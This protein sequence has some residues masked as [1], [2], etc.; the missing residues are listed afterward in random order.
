MKERL[1]G[2]DYR[3]VAVCLVLL[4]GTTWYSVR[5]FYRAFPEASIDFRVSR[6]EAQGLG[7]GFLSGLGYHIGGYREASSF[8]FDDDAKTFLEREAGLERANQLMET[9]VRLWRWSYRWFRPL[10]KEEF[11]AE[12]TTR[13][14]LA[15]FTHSLP[16]DAPLPAVSAAEASALAQD[17]LRARLHRDPASL[18]FVEASDVTRPHRTDRVFTWKERDFNLHDATIRLEVTVLGNQVGGYREYLKIP[19]Q[20]SRDYERLRSKNEM[21]QTVDTAVMLAL[22]VGMVVV[23][24]MRVRGQEIRW[25]RAA[26]V[27]TVGMAL[28][29]FSSLNE[30]P[31]HEFGYPTTDAYSAF[32]LR[33]L[34]QAVLA[35]LGAGGLLFVLTAGAE[36]LYREAFP[37]KVA[38][39]NLFRPR[40]LRTKRFFLGS[41]LGITLTGVFIAYQTFFYIVAYRFGAWSPADVP[42]SDLLN[43]RFPWLFVLFG[44][45]LP[46]VSEE[47]LFRMFA[48]PFLR[49]LVRS[50][51]VAVVLAGFIWGF[52]HAGYPQQPFYIRGVE[53]GIGG[54]ALGLIMLRWG[55]L[56]TLVW[57]YSVDAM[58]SA[59]LLL[60]SQSLYF[61]LSG[62]A[63][64]GIIVLP[65]MLALVA[66]WRR[67]GFEPE[68]GLLNADEVAPAEP[69]PEAQ[70]EPPAAAPQSRPLTARFRL[71]ALALFA[72]GLLSL[73]L[74]VNR[75]GDSPD[76]KL[77]SEQARNAA[78]AFL[79]AQGLDPA[80]Y[81]NVTF[82]SVHWGGDDSLAGKYLLERLPVSAASRL[83]ERY[84]PVQNWQSRY[85]KPLDQD[86]VLVSVQPETGRILGFRHTLPEDRPG[87]DVSEDTAR[88]VAS[89]FAAAQGWNVAD[90]DLKENNTEKKKARRDY[91][92][93][94]EARPGDPR[95]VAEAHYRVEVGVSGDRASSLRTYWKIPETFSRS[96]SQQNL[97]SISVLT[98]RIAVYAAGVVCGL[99]LLI[100]NIRTGKVRWGAAI[101]LA[102]PLTL[103]TAL[104]PV[105][106]WSVVLQNYN[107]AIPLA[108]FQAVM[109]ISVF[110]AVIFAFLL[111]GAAAAFLI[112]FHPQSVLALRPEN[113]RRLGAGAALALLAALGLGL[114][115]NRV[116]A[117][118]VDRFHAQALFSFSPPNLIVSAAPAV[119][120]L[121]GALRAILTDAAILAVIAVILHAV[122][123]RWMQVLLFLAAL[124]ASLSLEIRTLGEFALEYAVALVWGA[125]AVLF[126][127]RFARDN[128][129]AYAVALWVMVL[130]SPLLE[131]FGNPNPSLHMQGWLVAVVL[132]ATLLWVL[133]PGLGRPGLPSSDDGA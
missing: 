133:V 130:R 9:R 127:F 111:L 101:R 17:F 8:T 108:T 104:G 126:C 32:L 131:L 128:Y 64:A 85:F 20:W 11:R 78:G 69:P 40:G 19:D 96:R 83:F 66:Y 31:L 77:T 107:T 12:L 54:V 122:P 97:L 99:F 57:H 65:V 22:L 95:N 59:M 84:R 70:P 120:A 109:Y 124:C 105:L 113:R 82:P 98:L 76:Y 15:G 7:A 60:R 79:R 4:A 119:S 34:L 88:Q 132:V 80:A 25:R 2:S 123:K 94:W 27:G 100:R 35:A 63:S 28:S 53:V 42:Y 86:E 56:P 102:L 61:R 118:L 74:P 3:F 89:T 5:N 16:E 10:Q 36:A 58:Y 33:L 48:I 30:F 90:M 73:L 14:E 75:F 39:A 24:V 62:A 55:I 121:A 103:L 1:R 26:V 44:G 110:M 43:T 125:C 117:L 41:I 23:I 50:V 51:M 106:D 93:T 47:F 37:D 91:T 46:A 116:G 72:A 18:E 49:K 112:S 81:R 67:G 21:A 13:G 29:F 6:G 45:F 52:G 114:L 68:T 87:A 38:L 129:L 92:L 115:A 71:A